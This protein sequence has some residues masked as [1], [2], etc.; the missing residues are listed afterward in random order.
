ML[1][2]PNTGAPPLADTTL[3]RQEKTRPPAEILVVARGVRSPGTGP[4]DRIADGYGAYRSDA[5]DRDPQ[6][7]VAARPHVPRQAVPGDYEEEVLER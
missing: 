5:M 7:P 3:S 2:L 4:T 6:A 1:V